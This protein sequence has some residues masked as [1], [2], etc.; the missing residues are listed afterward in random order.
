[1]M[2]RSLVA[3]CVA[4]TQCTVVQ[5]VPTSYG[6]LVGIG[7]W[8][9]AANPVTFSW[10]VMQ[11]P[12]LSWHHHCEFDSTDV[13]GEVSHMPIEVSAAL[14]ASD[15]WDPTTAIEDGDPK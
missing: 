12:N 8:A 9:A 7:G 4:G 3:L 2:S 6:G 10:T 11:N 15:V 1:M 5:A 14:T 13:Q